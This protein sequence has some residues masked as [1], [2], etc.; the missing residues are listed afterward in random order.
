MATV[1]TQQE[2]DQ[3]L[4]AITVGNSLDPDDFKPVYE[5]CKKIKIY[6]FKRPDKFTREQIRTV[7]IIH[8]TFSRELTNMFSSLLK[9]T[10]HI[11]LASVD[12]LT[13]EEFVRS[14][15]TPTT[16]FPIEMKSLGKA[17]AEIDP[18]ITFSI[19]DCMFGGDGECLKAQHELTNIEKISMKTPINII[20]D[21]LK[22]MWSDIILT[23]INLI[24]IDT[25]PQI[26]QLTYPTEMGV[27]V[28]CEIKNNDV[29]GMINIFYPSLTLEPI[30]DKLNAKNWYGRYCDKKLSIKNILPT[31]NKIELDLKALLFRKEISIGELKNVSIGDVFI[32]NKETKYLI[33]G[34]T[35]IL[36]DFN[37]RYSEEGNK[38]LFIVIK[39]YNKINIMEKDYMD[40]KHNIDKIGINLDDVNVQLS[41]E[42]GRK[43]MLV[44]DILQLGEGSIVELDALAGDPVSIFANNV[45]IGR[46][47]TVVVDENFAVRL[48]EILS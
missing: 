25:T 30:L 6:D 40:E 43:K 37:T 11:H 26:I 5:G 41:V 42:L 1:L 19:I 23:E 38:D 14:V 4:T 8:E 22:K 16:L 48:T 34:N 24:S 15:P 47:E 28:T 39:L 32:F 12:Q 18:A 31:F 35:R 20:I 27:L 2:I 45:L 3:L 9:S 29:E 17:I 21:A 33:A 44:K 7:S 36:F 10:C 46:G 13:Y